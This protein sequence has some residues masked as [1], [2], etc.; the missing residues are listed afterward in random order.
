MWCTTYNF[1]PY[2]RDTFE[3]FINQRTSFR[4]KVFVFDDASTDGTDI[5]IREYIEKYPELF[6]AYICEKNT[7]NS[8][9]RNA[10][11]DKLFIE[12]Q[13]GRYVAQCEGDDYWN[14]PEKLSRQVL[15]LEKHPECSM[16]VHSA[17]WI[18]EVKGEKY[19]LPKLGSDHFLTAD[20]AITQA[21][22]R[23]QTASY[24]F[25]ACDN[26][27]EPAFPASHPWEYARILYEFA[28][29]KVYYFDTPMSTYRYRHVG[30][31]TEQYDNNIRFTAETQW[32]LQ[33]LLERY[34]EYTEFKYTK[35][36]NARLA[37]NVM[38][39]LLLC[40]SFSF[41]KYREEINNNNIL[42]ENNKVR[43]KDARERI[44][45]IVRGNY[46]FSDE[47]KSILNSCSH[48][49]I[50][51]CGEYSKYMRECIMYNGFR[52]DGYL[53]SDD[54]EIP[55][56]SN[57]HRLVDYPYDFEDTAVVIGVSQKFEIQ[58]RHELDKYKIRNVIDSFWI[59]SLSV[60]ERKSD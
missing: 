41:E 38:D 54:Q 6:D 43:F 42:S 27:P 3:G 50:Y 36:I 56:A 28:K 58:I 4:Y 46:F 34:N 40:S 29:G 15:F 20:E 8:P 33:T 30:S 60:C 23:I 21:S 26:N 13:E 25:R 57:I 37:S 10:L 55:E 49:C 53:I 39:A 2:V 7:Y 12:N 51:G 14:D 52:L 17:Y 35:S 45:S 44:G 1:A 59:H 47:E 19:I 24:V 48:I 32:N 22:G 18:D 31:W 5:I 16:V 9:D 11:M